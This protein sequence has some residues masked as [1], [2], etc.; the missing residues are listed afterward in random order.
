MTAES[1][2]RPIESGI[3]I[4]SA[5]MLLAP[6]QDALA[7]L[8]GATLSPGEITFVRFAIQTAI[9]ASVLAVRGR[10]R[11]PRAELRLLA[12]S[13]LF[14]AGAILLMVWAVQT[15]PIAN[16]IA[17]FFV[18]PLILTLLGAVVLREPVGW[19]RF[20]A[21]AIGLVGALV[22]IRPNW[23]LFGWPALL[24][25]CTAVLF[26]SYLTVTRRMGS[27]LTGMVMQT[28]AGM[29]AALYLGVAL[30]LGSAGGLAPFAV[31]WP[32]AQA[33]GLL[34]LLGVAS[35][36]VHV[37]VATALT[38]AAASI[39]APF[40]Y[41]EILSATALGYLL[42]DDFPDALTWLGTA[43]IL[44]SGL[45]VFHRERRLARRTYLGPAP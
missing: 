22:V 36:T 34:V 29:F 12:L 8:L 39:I 25:L 6:G 10:L 26:A 20:G 24:P 37:L 40:Q 23:A 17:I 44:A 19:R 27:T 41:L 16:A 33:W 32:D 4:M 43:I 2:A 21:C 42:F 14:L 13:G 30:L 31:R 35:G 5:A 28:W 18:E 11:F 7:K 45:Y 3:A 9:L 15:L 1:S 38:R